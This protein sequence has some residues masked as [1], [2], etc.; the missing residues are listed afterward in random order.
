MAVG[1]VKISIS[2]P[3]SFVE[4]T[5][6]DESLRALALAGKAP[7]NELLGCY[8][9]TAEIRNVYKGGLPFFMKAAYMTKLRDKTITESDISSLRTSAASAIRDTL[10][11]ESP[12][13][14]AFIREVSGHISQATSGDVSLSVPVT[15][16]FGIVASENDHFTSLIMANPTFTLPGQTINAPYLVATTYGLVKGRLLFLYTYKKFQNGEDIEA[17]QNFAREWFARIRSDNP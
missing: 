16:N 14:K 3:D 6:L 17:I 8:A 5:S 12:K 9:G 2:L 13:Y 11:P 15:A 1:D 10:T 4:F 7:G